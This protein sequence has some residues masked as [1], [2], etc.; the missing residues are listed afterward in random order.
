M[1]RKAVSAAPWL[2]VSRSQLTYRCQIAA[3]PSFSCCRVSSELCM[4]AR[5]YAATVRSLTAR[6][7]AWSRTGPDVPEDLA[8]GSISQSM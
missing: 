1:A 7:S 5:E 6:M 3:S 4:P 8:L 2:S